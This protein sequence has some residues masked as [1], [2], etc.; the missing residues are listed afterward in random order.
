MPLRPLTAQEEALP[1]SKF[2]YIPVAMPTEE[3]EACI[4]TPMDPEKAI[5]PENFL[6]SLTARRIPENENKHCI[7]PDGTI[8]AHTA[9]EL[10]DVE[11]PMLGWWFPWFLRKPELSDSTGNLRYRLWDPLDHW[12][13]QGDVMAESFDDGV[14]GHVY[15]TDHNPL[16]LED[17]GVPQEIRD[18][19]KKEGVMASCLLNKT[20]GLA[21]RVIINLTQ[22]L[23]TGGFLMRSHYWFNQ[24]LLDGKCVRDPKEK[25]FD[26]TLA[27]QIHRHNLVEKRHLNRILPELFRECGHLK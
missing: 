14:S 16:S 3:E 1:Y 19:L 2:Y 12:D 11:G 26:E 17:L 9:T 13:T 7:L 24:T 22:P 27:T 6:D 23:P 4:R 15:Y 20:E 5:L 25:Q 8:Y 21:D 18:E 10:P